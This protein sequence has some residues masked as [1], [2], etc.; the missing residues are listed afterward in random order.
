MKTLEKTI[1]GV[2][3]WNIGII[4]VKQFINCPYY[5]VKYTIFLLTK[6]KKMSQVIRG[7]MSQ[8]KRYEADVNMKYNNIDTKN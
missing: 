1:P 6:N 4:L 3:I 7:L 5:N 2:Q 8:V